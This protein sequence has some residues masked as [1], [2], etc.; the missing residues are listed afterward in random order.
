MDLLSWT[1]VRM[2]TGRIWE[3]WKYVVLWYTLYANVALYKTKKTIM[4][5]LSTIYTYTV[6]PRNYSILKVENVD[7]FIKFSHYGN[8][9]LQGKKLFAGI[10]YAS[11]CKVELPPSCVK[12]VNQVQC[13]Q[14]INLIYKNTLGQDKLWIIFL[15]YFPPF[16]YEIDFLHHASFWLSNNLCDSIFCSTY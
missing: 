16:S 4:I 15:N 1:C 9:L 8:F 5:V 14:V 13:I 6:F 3:G 12:Y 10:R 11:M 7:F 2:E